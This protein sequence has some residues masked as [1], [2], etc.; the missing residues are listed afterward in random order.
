M[1][2]TEVTN[3][4]MDRFISVGRASLSISE[5]TD[6]RGTD[7]IPVV[8]LHAG[9]ADRRSWAAVFAELHRLQPGLRLISYDRRGFGET[10][11][12]AEPSSAVS[13]L[14][15]VLDACDVHQAILVGNSQGGRI[16]IDTAL[17][18]PN[19]VA[20]L[21]LIGSAVSGAPKPRKDE[22]A[23]IVDLV[24]A[25]DAAEESGNLEQVNKLEA[26]LWL[27]GMGP[28]GRVSGEARSLFLQMNGRALQANE[29][30][31]LQ[32]V[33]DAWNRLEEIAVP[34]MVIVGERDLPHL[35]RQSAEIA[36]RVHNAQLIELEN[37][38]HVPSLEDPVG[39]ANHLQ[40][41]IGE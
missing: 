35:V 28:M 29:V 16:A 2:P 18:Y 32:W 17:T 5:V 10:T 25:I 41:F 21:V 11:Y 27:D 1:G 36:S 23:A 15:A 39:L 30:G 4:L 19:R 34:T 38:A 40:A 13:D 26:H 24:N 6:G 20:K 9:V 31:N 37:Q 12:E 33:T 3:S 8:F 22:V 7:G 14:I